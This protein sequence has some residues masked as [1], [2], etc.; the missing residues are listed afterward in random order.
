MQ[1]RFDGPDLGQAQ[2]IVFQVKA[3]LGISERVIALISTLGMPRRLAGLDAPEEVLEG[4]VR[5]MHDV[6][7]GLRVDALPFG[8][9]LLPAGSGRLLLEARGRPP[10]A[11]AVVDAPVKERIVEVAAGVK[12]VRENAGLCFAGV[13]PVAGRPV[14]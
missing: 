14:H 12:G 7:Q 4:P 13:E 5:A 10:E 2:P 6:L 8:V 1:A 11:V 3:A 9:G